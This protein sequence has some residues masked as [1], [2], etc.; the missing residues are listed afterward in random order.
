MLWI[1]WVFKCLAGTGWGAGVVR[2]S[3]VAFLLETGSWHLVPSRSSAGA[4]S[5]RP[6]FFSLGVFLTDNWA[7]LQC[8]SWGPRR[9]VPTGE[10]ALLLHRVLPLHSLVTATH[11]ASTYLRGEEI[12]ASS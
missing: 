4:V 2:R 11:T 7:S 1:D 8:G 5:W 6:P 10:D 9:D 12:D 3:S